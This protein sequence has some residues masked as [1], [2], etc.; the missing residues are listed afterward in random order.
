MAWGAFVGTTKTDLIFIPDKAK[1]DSEVYT[2]T[3]LDPILI[4]FWHEMC[5]KYE[6]T[7]VIEDGAP[8]HKGVSR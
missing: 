8:G 7:K 4:P 6:W 3:I 5:E 2:K 1:M